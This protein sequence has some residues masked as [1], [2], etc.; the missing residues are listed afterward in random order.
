MLIILRIYNNR[1]IL[2]NKLRNKYYYSE[3]L[4]VTPKN[5]YKIYNINNKYKNK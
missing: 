4:I 1:V 3:K 2:L 5:K